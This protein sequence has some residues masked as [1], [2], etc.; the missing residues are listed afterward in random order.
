MKINQIRDI[1]RCYDDGGTV[2]SWDVITDDGPATVHATLAAAVQIE[3]V[4]VPIEITP[5][6]EFLATLREW[7]AAGIGTD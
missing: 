4:G 2:E 3:G 5:T 6:P 7:Q 1:A